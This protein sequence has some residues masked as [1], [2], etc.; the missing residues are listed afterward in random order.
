M[1]PDEQH[2]KVVFAGMTSIYN[3]YVTTSEEYLA[4]RYEGASTLYGPYTLL[5]YQQQ[6]RFLAEKLVNGEKILHLGPLAPDLYE[7]AKNFNRGLNRLRRV[8][9]DKPPRGKN[10]G[11]CILQPPYIV[12]KGIDTVEVEFVSGHLRNNPLLEGSFL[13]VEKMD[14][15]NWEIV[16]V[17]T[18]IET[19]LEW[20]R[21]NFLQGQSKIRISWKIPLKTKSGKYRIRHVGS[22]KK[23]NIFWNGK[24]VDYEGSTRPFQVK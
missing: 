4:Q 1:K 5:A 15:Q 14:H 10:F 23:W 2:S 8:L 16:A 24:V 22:Y 6:Y 11:D 21:T 19:R 13:Y 9:F 12:K 3:H 18:D 20:I 7:T 17:D